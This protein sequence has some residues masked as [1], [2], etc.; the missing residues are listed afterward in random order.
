MKHFWDLMFWIDDNINH[1]IWDWMAGEENNETPFDKLF[2]N[3]CQWS[4]LG[5]F[6]Y[7]DKHNIDIKYDNEEGIQGGYVKDEMEFPKI[8]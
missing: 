6:D 5:W 4:T 8:R 7:M 2:F 1:P 3:F